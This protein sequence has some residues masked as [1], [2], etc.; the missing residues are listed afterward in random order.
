MDFGIR[1]RRALVL[2][3]GSGL[4]RAIAKELAIEG[5]SV[6][7]AGRTSNSLIET[8]A[9]IEAFGGDASWQAWDLADLEAGSRAIDL[10]EEE[11]GPIEILINNTGG[12]PP[13]SVTRQSPVDWAAHFHSMVLSVIAITDR[14]LPGMQL[15]QWGRIVTSTSSG[16]VAPIPNLG[17]SNSLRSSLV[18]W[19]KS[20]ATEVAKYGITANVVVPG[21][22]DTRRVQNLDM[23]RAKRDEKSIEEIVADSQR[24]I[25]MGRYG[26]VE[27]YAAAVAFL[28]SARA[29][30]ITGSQM[31]VDGG[32]IAGI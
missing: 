31:R 20:L 1:D 17:I 22:I 8:V 28:C 6:V 12:P 13:G 27:E 9:Q 2:G 16:V 29:S 25:P 32:Q 24:M 18:G 15:A 11:V 23:A 30:Y 19:S 3:A 4:G 14:V 7:C 5:V 26:A 10:I 21:R